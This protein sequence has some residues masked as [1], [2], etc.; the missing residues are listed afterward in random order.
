M[1]PSRQKLFFTKESNIKSRNVISFEKKFITKLKKKNRH[2]KIK[3]CET[4]HVLYT[5]VHTHTH[6]RAH[7]K[8]CSNL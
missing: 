6:T 7:S 4:N 3:Y 2:N 5:H 1:T 8:S